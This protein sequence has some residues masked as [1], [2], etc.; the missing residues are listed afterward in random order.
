MERFEIFTNKMLGSVR[1]LLGEDGS[2]WFFANDVLEILGY[3]DMSHTLS[4]HTSPNDR[5]AVKYCDWVKMTESKDHN[6]KDRIFINESGLYC[7]IFGS[8]LPAA[9][10]FKLW[11]TKEVLPSIRKNGGYIMGQEN[12]SPEAQTDL[13]KEVQKLSKEVKAQTECADMFSKFYDDLNDVYLRL[14]KENKELSEGL[15]AALDRLEDN[16]RVITV[17]STGISTE[18]EYFYDNFGNQYSTREDA[19]DAIK[20]ARER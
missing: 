19:I 7:L 20:A 5:K 3:A 4:D 12:L 6:R 9:Q 15:K 8:K 11:V 2:V 17:G 13:A 10:D 1:T 14:K 16:E 18:L